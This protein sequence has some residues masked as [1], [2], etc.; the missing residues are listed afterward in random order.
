MRFCGLLVP[1]LGL[2]LASAAHGAP[3]LFH[4]HGH[5]LSFS[6]DGG[7][8]ITPSERGLAIYEGGRWDETAGDSGGFSGF[9]ASQRAL[10]SSGHAQAGHRARGLIRSTDVGRTWRALAFATRRREAYVTGDGGA[11]WRR[12]SVEEKQSRESE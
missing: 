1:T 2:L 10:Y 5:G 4:E 6:A 11:H 7:A 12:I 9:S 3:L 8:L